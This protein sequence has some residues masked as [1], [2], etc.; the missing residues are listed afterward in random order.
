VTGQ[1]DAVNH[2]VKPLAHPV[3]LPHPVEDEQVWGI[4]A[5][6]GA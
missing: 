6:W 3:T 2:N 5:T 1:P 4:C